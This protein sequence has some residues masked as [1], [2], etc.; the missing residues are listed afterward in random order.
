MSNMT[1]QQK[2][3]AVV[4]ALAHTKFLPD[5]FASI[6]D[7]VARDD[8]EA[9]DATFIA[10]SY[11]PLPG[12]KD[13]DGHRPVYTLGAFP[14]QPAPAGPGSR[15]LTVAQIAK[16]VAER[17]ALWSQYGDAALAEYAQLRRPVI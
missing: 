13:L 17:E 14:Q 9:Q 5:A 11:Q 6:R 1:P 12:R 15:W 10:V 3:D 8:R 16:R 4:K 2:A 7:M